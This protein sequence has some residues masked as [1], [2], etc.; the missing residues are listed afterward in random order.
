MQR[1]DRAI[2]AGR[3][4]Q[5]DGMGVEVGITEQAAIGMFGRAAFAMLEQRRRQCDLFDARAGL[6]T[7]GQNGLTFDGRKT[8]T[9]GTLL[10]G[11]KVASEIVVRKSPDQ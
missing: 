2:S 10:G 1:S 5:D 6:A 8:G 4:V 9:G 7:T 3:H 11:L